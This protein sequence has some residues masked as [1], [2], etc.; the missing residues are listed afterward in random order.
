MLPWL[1]ALAPLGCDDG[2]STSTGS[3][4]TTPHP[5]DAEVSTSSPDAPSDGLSD[6]RDVTTLEA[7]ATSDAAAGADASVDAFARPDA[8]PAPLLPLDHPVPAVCRGDLAPGAK[9]VFFDGFPAGSEGIAAGADALYVSTPRTGEVWRLAPDATAAVFARVP[10]ALGMGFLS[11]GRLAVADIGD[12]N[13][14]GVAD[15]GV[16]LVDSAGVATPLARDMESPNFVTVLPDDS[17]LVSDDF[18]TRIWHVTLD[19][20]VKAAVEDVPS[21]NGMAFNGAHD[22]LLVAST[23][24]AGGEIT[25]FPLGAD[26]LPDPTAAQVLFTNGA[27][28]T[29]DGVALDGFDQLYVA[30]NIQG[31][32]A[33]HRAD[34]SGEVVIVAEGLRTP[35]SL[36]FGRAPGFDPCS[37]Y[38]TE[39][40]GSRI[41]RVAVGAEGAPLP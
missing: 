21:P 35:A 14:P 31:K 34:G 8:A 41:W 33:R 32:L 23:F 6:G 15:G 36:A 7:D 4:G 37:L 40:V 2:A 11:D 27:G 1:L 20:Q 28:L 30:R 12:S 39:L 3:G 22:R 10:N 24:S 25:A 18:D 26:G 29:Q 17:L 9:A 16:W 38:V 5:G 13:T 19:G